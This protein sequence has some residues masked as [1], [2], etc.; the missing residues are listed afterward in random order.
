MFSIDK[1]SSFF[2]SFYLAVLDRFLL[3]TAN[4][5]IVAEHDNRPNN[6]PPTAIRSSRFSF[7]KKYKYTCI[8]L[9]LKVIKRHSPIFK[10]MKKRLFSD[11]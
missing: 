1:H 6:P 10:K 9:S 11:Q 3:L 4:K 5:S 7:S 2:K 8:D